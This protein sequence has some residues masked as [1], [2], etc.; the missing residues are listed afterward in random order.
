MTEVTPNP[1]FERTRIG[2][3]PSGV[4]LIQPKQ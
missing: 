1:A 3:G 2:N 4:T